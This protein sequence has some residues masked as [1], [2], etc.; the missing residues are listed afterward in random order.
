MRK[1]NALTEKYVVVP[2][3]HSFHG[4]RYIVELQENHW[5]TFQLLERKQENIRP[6]P[7]L[8]EFPNWKLNKNYPKEHHFL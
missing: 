5:H 1:L 2:D 7:V 8:E 4:L 3:Q 6:C